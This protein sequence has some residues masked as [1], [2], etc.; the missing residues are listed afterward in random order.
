MFWERKSTCNE[1]FEVLLLFVCFLYVTPLYFGCLGL[2]LCVFEMMLDF[3]ANEGTY[4][5]VQ[6]F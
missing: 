3:S 1:C 6:A 5:D 2:R 4:L